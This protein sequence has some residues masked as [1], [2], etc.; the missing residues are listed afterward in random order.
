MAWLKDTEGRYLMA[1]KPFTSYFKK[2]LQTLSVKKIRKYFLTQSLPFMNNMTVRLSNRVRKNFMKMNGSLKEIH[3][4][5][6]L[7]SIRYMTK[8]KSWWE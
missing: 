7:F 3:H 5:S 1:N 4:G 6:K 2:T 8:I